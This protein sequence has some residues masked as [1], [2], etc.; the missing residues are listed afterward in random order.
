MVGSQ[1]G[2][3]FDGR[4]TD[5]VDNGQTE[6]SFVTNPDYCRAPWAGAETETATMGKQRQMRHL[7]RKL[8]ASATHAGL[9]LLFLQNSRSP[10]GKSPRFLPQITAETAQTTPD[11]HTYLIPT[12]PQP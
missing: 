7:P 8:L 3:K 10:L 9:A 5:Y 4:W 11:E 2:S 6:S 12:E 1:V